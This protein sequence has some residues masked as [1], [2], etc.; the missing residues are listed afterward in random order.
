MVKQATDKANPFIGMGAEQLLHHL[1]SVRVMQAEG[2]KQ[3]ELVMA[4]I[5]PIVDPL[6]D[7]PL[8]SD[9]LLVLGDLQLE[10]RPGEARS[11]S[12]QA[13]LDN[14]VDIEII[15]KSTKVSKYYQYRVSE[16]G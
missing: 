8:K 3:E 12:A 15:N 7:D 5:K 10:R 11:I 2:R 14:G 1:R 6:F 9:N 13:L 16:K 4:A